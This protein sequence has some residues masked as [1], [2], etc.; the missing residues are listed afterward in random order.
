MHVGSIF[1]TVHCGKTT[2]MLQMKKLR[3]K[4]TSSLLMVTPSMRDR[5]GFKPQAHTDAVTASV[6]SSSWE[7]LWVRL[8]QP[9]CLG[10][11]SLT[12]DLVTFPGNLCLLPFFSPWEAWRQW[13][14]CHLQANSP[15]LG[16]CVL[17]KLRL[18]RTGPGENPASLNPSPFDTPCL[19]MAPQLELCPTRHHVRH[20]S[21]GSSSTPHRLTKDRS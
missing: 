18:Q 15:A 21:L 10:P 9:M 19:C 6:L 20:C 7:P 8:P 2:P 16:D 3:Y 17:A 1:P 13:E 5:G 11:S 14:L 12:G 4:W